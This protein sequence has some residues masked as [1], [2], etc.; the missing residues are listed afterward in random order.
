MNEW[1]CIIYMIYH[2][3]DTYCDWVICVSTAMSA[4]GVWC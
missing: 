4:V 3:Y 1:V 2:L